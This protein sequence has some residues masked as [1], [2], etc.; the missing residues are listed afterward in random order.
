MCSHR[1]MA[2]EVCRCEKNLDRLLE[3]RIL[4]IIAKKPSHGYYILEVLSEKLSI[5]APDPGLIYRTLRQLEKRGLVKSSWETDGSGPA[6]RIYEITNA[7][8]ERLEGWH[9]TLKHHIKAL[10]ELLSDFES[11]KEEV[12]R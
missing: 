12:S 5:N 9:I 2:E 10:S 7:G 4:L 1:D 6:R 8:W 11:L 3:P